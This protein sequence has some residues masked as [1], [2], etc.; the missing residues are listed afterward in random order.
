MYSSSF[1][2][3][4]KTEIVLGFMANEVRMNDVSIPPLNNK[5]SQLFFSEYLLTIFD[6]FSALSIAHY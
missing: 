5:Q 6:N 3:L 4:N 1:E 2:S